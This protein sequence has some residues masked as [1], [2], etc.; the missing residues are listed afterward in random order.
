MKRTT[1]SKATRKVAESKR[2]SQLFAF[3]I[4]V[5]KD[6][7]SSS[8]QTCQMIEIYY[9]LRVRVTARFLKGI[10]RISQSLKMPIK[11]YRQYFTVDEDRSDLC[12]F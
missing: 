11:V 3:L 5:P 7:P 8:Q 2:R 9:Y 1:L 4:Q 6:A 12:L 10:I